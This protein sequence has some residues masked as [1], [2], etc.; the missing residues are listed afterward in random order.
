[1]TAR[2]PDDVRFE[3]DPALDAKRRDFTI[4]GLMEDPLSGEMFDFVGGRADL[5]NHTIARLATQASVF[6]KIICGCFGLCD[7][8][9]AST[10]QLKRIRE[11][12]S[13][14]RPA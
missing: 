14:S 13:A 4:N 8:R 6:V 12:R 9:R 1:M 2:R 10:F 5:A 3:T 11:Q 7:L